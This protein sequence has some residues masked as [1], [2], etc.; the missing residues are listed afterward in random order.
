MNKQPDFGTDL[1][2]LQDSVTA[3]VGDVLHALQQKRSVGRSS[4][5]KQEPRQTPPS[6]ATTIQPKAAVSSS[7]SHAPQKRKAS[8]SRLVPELE[9]DD[10]LENVTTRLRQRTNKLLTEAALRQRLKKETPATRQDIVE[11]ALGDWFRKHGYLRAREE[12]SDA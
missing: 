7:E 8:R 12:N 4:N 5:A 6:L 1:A 3:E 10:P 2:S 11:A 9:R